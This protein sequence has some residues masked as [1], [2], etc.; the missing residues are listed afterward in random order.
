MAFILLRHFVRVLSVRM[1]T[2]ATVARARR[3]ATQGGH[4]ARPC[5]EENFEQGWAYPDD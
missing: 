5:R 1:G 4:G 2:L 3:A